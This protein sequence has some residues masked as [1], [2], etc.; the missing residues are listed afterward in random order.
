M[1][2]TAVT[3][4]LDSKHFNAIYNNFAGK[5]TNVILI[6]FSFAKEFN[7]IQFIFEDAVFN[8]FV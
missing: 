4:S 6:I 2:E 1:I 8:G 7:L 3:M 5:T